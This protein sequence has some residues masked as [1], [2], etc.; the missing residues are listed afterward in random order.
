MT[1]YLG[2]RRRKGASS[3]N[4]NGG[5]ALWLRYLTHK[6]DSNLTICEQEGQEAATLSVSEKHPPSVPQPNDDDD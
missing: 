5:V 6:R 2:I 4:S 3:G 1:S